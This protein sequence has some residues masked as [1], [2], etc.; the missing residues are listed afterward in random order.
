M[1]ALGWE[2]LAA[3]TGLSL[4]CPVLLRKGA[5]A[6]SV[7][8]LLNSAGARW[9]LPTYTRDELPQCVQMAPSAGHALHCIAHPCRYKGYDGQPIL[10]AFN[11]DVFDV[12]TGA[13]FYGPEGGYKIFAGVDATRSLSM[14]SLDEADVELPKCADLSDF[15]QHDWTS[16]FE[17]HA[18]YAEKYTR[19]GRLVGSDGSPVTYLL[20][21]AREVESP[22]QKVH[23]K[24][25]TKL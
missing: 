20:P 14:G 2:H 21:G 6:G 11:G 10:L 1:A 17:Q 18:F 12:S 24:K 5:S 23:V 9:A 13:R 16:F 4:T 3:L 19:V 25:D 7:A 22:V 15:K 8:L